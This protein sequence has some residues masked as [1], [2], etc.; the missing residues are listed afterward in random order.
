MADDDS[1]ALD[2]TFSG[3]DTSHGILTDVLNT[4][5]RVLDNGMQNIVVAEL[6]FALTLLS[7]Q[8]V[9]V[10]IHAGVTRH[11]TAHALMDFIG[12]S[13]WF[14][15]AKNGV[16]IVKMFTAWM[17]SIGTA[18]GGGAMEGDIMNNPSLVVGLAFRSV[19]NLMLSMVKTI[20][21]PFTALP[22]V[23][24]GTFLALGILIG[25]GWMA[26]QI[27]L[28]VIKAKINA[29]VGIALLPF[30]IEPRTAFLAGR[31]LG[32]IVDSAISL[33]VTSVTIGIGYGLL[34]KL[35]IKP[36]FMDAPKQAVYL[37]LSAVII[38]VLTGG[39]NTMLKGAALALRVKAGIAKFG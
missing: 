19:G 26:C 3:L 37:I 11:G 24:I 15:I 6:A 25:L 7:A 13:I 27:V 30:A 5:S 16:N 1:Q 31:G 35:E 9:K 14:E 36:D 21:L 18:V 8:F 28:A 2:I 39:L 4:F 33:G 17:G 10:V 20:R 23:W 12:A 38:V 32:L 29:V 34:S 22:T